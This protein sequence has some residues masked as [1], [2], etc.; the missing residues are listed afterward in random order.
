MSLTNAKSHLKLR[1]E[2][3]P[4]NKTLKRSIPTVYRTAV[5][6]I[7]DSDKGLVPDSFQ[8]RYANSYVVELE[9]MENVVRGSEEILVHRADAVNGTFVFLIPTHL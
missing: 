2:T 7:S 1:I 5:G 4:F 8:K 3:S 9:H 6:E